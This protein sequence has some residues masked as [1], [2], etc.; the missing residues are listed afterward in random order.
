MGFPTRRDAD[1][2]KITYVIPMRQGKSKLYSVPLLA[3]FFGGGGYA[4]W[5]KANWLVIKYSIYSIRQYS[6]FAN[7]NEANYHKS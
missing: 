4:F 7:D 1:L 6:L 2:P 5:Y 3:I